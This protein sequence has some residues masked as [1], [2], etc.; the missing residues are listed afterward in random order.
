[1]QYGTQKKKDA[2]VRSPAWQPACGSISEG[3]QLGMPMAWL[4]CIW[5]EEPGRS[6]T[7]TCAWQTRGGAAGRDCLGVSDKLSAP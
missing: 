3:T 4:G 7:V 2:L 5:S 6:V 1:M